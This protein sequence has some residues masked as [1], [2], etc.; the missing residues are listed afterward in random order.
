MINRLPGF[1]CL[2]LLTVFSITYAPAQD[3]TDQT[4]EN[5]DQAQDDTGQAQEGTLPLDEIRTLTEVFAKVKNDYV[6]PVD[7]REILENAI[8]G[9]L[10]GLDPHSAYLNKEAYLELQEGTSGEFGGLGIEVGMEDGFVKVISPIDGTPAERAGIMPG[11]LII[12]LDDTPVKGM[13]LN[14]SV[15]IMRGKPGTQITLTVVR[16]DQE[17]PLDI[18]IIRD[19]IKIKSVRSRILEPGFG[20]LRVSHFQLHTPDDLRTEL[21]KIRDENKDNFKGLILDLRNN[22]GGILSAAVAVSDFFLDKGLIVYTE[23]RVSDSRLKFTAKPD[24]ILDN[25]PIVV[26]VNAG[27]ASASEIVA[28]ALQDHKRAIIMGQQTFGK[29]SVQTILPMSSESA[30]KL[31]TAL[32][33]TPSGRSIQA[34][35][36]TPDIIIDKIKIEDIEEESNII[37]ESN[38]SGHLDNK[39]ET[40]NDDEQTTDS[41]KK[42]KP[43]SRRPLPTG[44]YELYEALNVL[45]GLSILKPTAG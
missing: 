35:G 5:T 45:K 42:E 28:G 27:S 1:I 10:E 12:R 29:G 40:D 19:V 24:D 2:A 36:I 9:M 44:D 21:S 15:N 3:D 41:G 8:R 23:G 43:V 11:D 18:V 17:K 31:T 34:S 37:K 22:P 33:Y 13:S 32:Y 38:L 20:Y 16:E 7:D 6:E 25:A 14:E 26:L 30:L 39:T 4:Q